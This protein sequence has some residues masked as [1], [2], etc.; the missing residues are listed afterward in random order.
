[1]NHSLTA[2]TFSL[3]ISLLIRNIWSF[4]PDRSEQV[5]NN[6]L[7]SRLHNRSLVKISKSFQDKCM[8]SREL[9]GFK[10]SKVSEWCIALQ[11]HIIRRA[12]SNFNRNLKFSF[13]DTVRDFIG[14]FVYL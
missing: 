8:F 2:T 7:K 1:M 3:R 10:I 14:D 9:S 11:F 5:D 13:F 4:E 6:D 12:Y